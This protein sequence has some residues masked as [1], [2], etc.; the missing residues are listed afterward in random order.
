MLQI[1]TAHQKCALKFDFLLSLWGA[2][3]YLGGAL[4]LQISPI[5]YAPNPPWGAR[6]PS[7][8]PGYACE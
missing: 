4:H 3:T 7:A 2:L 6:A 8:P 5:N 1:S